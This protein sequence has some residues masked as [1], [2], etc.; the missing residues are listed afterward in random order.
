MASV[1][2]RA[3][4]EDHENSLLTVLRELATQSGLRGLS[5]SARPRRAR[6]PVSSAG[7]GGA[8]VNVRI[9]IANDSKMPPVSSAGQGGILQIRTP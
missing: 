2:P 9:E 5:E 6:G 3:A 7:Q 4:Y 8:T 1:P